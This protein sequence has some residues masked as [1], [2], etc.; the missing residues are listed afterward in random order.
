MLRALMSI[1]VC[2]TNHIPTI[3][4]E[5]L[6]FLAL[7]SEK[8]SPPNQLDQQNFNQFI[9][10]L[11]GYRSGQYFRPDYEPVRQSFGVSFN[12]WFSVYDFFFVI[13]AWSEPLATKQ[14][15]SSQIP[16]PLNSLKNSFIVPLPPSGRLSGVSW[17]FVH[18]NLC[19]RLWISN[20]CE[21]TSPRLMRVYQ[22]SMISLISENSFPITA[23]AT[24]KRF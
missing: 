18:I 11:D 10:D 3:Q 6:R 20:L 23:K 21:E 1:F 13:E 5:D 8:Q 12:Y 15:L 2:V 19:L 24:M 7:S 14:K 22:G 17:Q 16:D 4:E 9:D